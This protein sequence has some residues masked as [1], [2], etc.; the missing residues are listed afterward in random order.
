MYVFF[1]VAGNDDVAMCPSWPSNLPYKR[2]ALVLLISQW[3][4]VYSLPDARDVPR[5]RKRCFQGCPTTTQSLLRCLRRLGLQW[6]WA[7]RDCY[8]A[9]L[10]SRGLPAD[11]LQGF[12]LEER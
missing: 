5:R 9:V 6:I 2:S 10:V 1:M 4:D 12:D 7:C 8:V 3:A 11:V